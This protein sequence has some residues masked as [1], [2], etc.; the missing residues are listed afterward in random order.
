MDELLTELWNRTYSDEGPP[1]GLVSSGLWIA[2]KHDLRDW[3]I[4][5]N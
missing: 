3:I 1:I 2:V 4:C 5:W